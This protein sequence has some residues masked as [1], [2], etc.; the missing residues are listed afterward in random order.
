MTFELYSGSFV[1]MTIT[2]LSFK[3]STYI[4]ERE[5]SGTPVTISSDPMREGG[6]TPIGT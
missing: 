3:G 4:R 5:G 6:L 1:R 2:S